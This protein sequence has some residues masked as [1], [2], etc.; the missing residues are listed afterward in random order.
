MVLEQSAKFTTIIQYAT[1]QTATLE[2]LSRNVKL[3][4]VI[5]FFEYYSLFYSFYTNPAADTDRFCS[6]LQVNRHHLKHHVNL[7]L[8]EQTL[9]AGFLV[10][11]H[12]VHAYLVTPDLH[13]TAGLNVSPTAN[14]VLIKLA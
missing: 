12:P 4:K 11:R 8:V 7:H 13:H 9:F 5:K 14:V 6:H 2:I 1:V 3:C 10:K